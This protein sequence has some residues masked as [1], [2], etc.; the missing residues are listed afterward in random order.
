[1]VSQKDM[2]KKIKCCVGPD[3]VVQNCAMQNYKGL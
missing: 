1:M 2:K 3:F